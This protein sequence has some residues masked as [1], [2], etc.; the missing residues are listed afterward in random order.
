M[1]Y[2]KTTKN[3]LYSDENTKKSHFCIQRG[4]YHLINVLKRR[5]AGKLLEISN[6]TI[7]QTPQRSD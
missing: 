1:M 5:D 6:M 7:A 2:T 4:M 3:G